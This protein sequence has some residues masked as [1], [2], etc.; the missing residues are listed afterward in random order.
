[1]GLGGC[2]WFGGGQHKP[3]LAFAGTADTTESINLGNGYGLN[4]PLSVAGFERDSV[5]LGAGGMD[6]SADYTR[7][8]APGTV[9]ATVSVHA[10]AG[11]GSFAVIP[12]TGGG[13]GAATQAQSDRALTAAVA[14]ATRGQAGAAEIGRGNVFLVRFGVVQ[15]GRAATVTATGELGGVRQSVR[16]LLQ[17]FCCVGGKWDYEYR[18]VAPADV[19]AREMENEFAR[20]VAWSREPAGSVEQPE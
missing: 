8:G 13:S 15:A 4:L 18:F 9:S 17:S 16:V 11:G 1:M 5:Q 14:A 6:A 20:A 2:G 7:R 19:D 10:A 3:P 12:F